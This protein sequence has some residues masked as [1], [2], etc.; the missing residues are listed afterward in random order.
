MLYRLK[1]DVAVYVIIF[2]SACRGLES[3]WLKN[4]AW[5]FRLRSFQTESHL[6]RLPGLQL[7]AVGITDN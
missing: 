4:G 2:P 1:N 3:A 7:D 6:T 5:M